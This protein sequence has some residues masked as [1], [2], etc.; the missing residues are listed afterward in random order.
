MTAIDPSNLNSTAHLTFDDEFNTLNLWNG[1]SGT[2]DTDAAWDSP[3]DNGYSLGSNGEQQWYIN[4]NYAATSAF[5][6]WTVG[7]GVLNITGSVAPASVQPLI[8]NYH[9]ISGQLNT[10]KSYSQL[11]GYFEVSAKLPAGQGFWPAFWLL[12]ENGSWPP[13][14]D[15]MESLGNKTSTYYTTVHFAAD[16]QSIGQTINSGVDLSA[17]FHTYGVDWESDFITWY[18]DGKQVFQAATPS[19]MH[20]PMYMLLNLALGGYWPGNV[21]STTNLSNPMQVDWVRAYQSG[22]TS[23]TV[24]TVGASGG[25]GSTLTAPSPAVG[26]STPSNSR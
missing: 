15:V 2:W 18:L 24:G 22:P 5:K 13:E 9:Y 4:S 14:L 10:S 6:P 11:Y 12:P 16:N 8:N 20:S 7:S 21:D 25:S 23:T 19:D 17:G 26:A 1:G 3:A